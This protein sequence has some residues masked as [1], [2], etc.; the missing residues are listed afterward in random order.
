MYV[1][2]IH[3]TCYFYSLHNNI[4]ILDMYCYFLLSLDIFC[5][6][7]VTLTT[8]CVWVCV[9]M[10]V[11]ECVCVCVCVYVLG[12]SEKKLK[13]KKEG[14]YSCLSSS[15]VSMFRANHSNIHHISN[16]TFLHFCRCKCKALKVPTKQ[17]DST[18]KP[19]TP[20]IKLWI[21]N[22]DKPDAP[23]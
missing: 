1:I 17:K 7:N 19:N 15:A 8:V 10:W 4:S 14:R 12:G 6:L 16:L 18:G 5:S 11:C 21:W 2:K 9:W 23:F 13:N 3:S 20:A 22:C